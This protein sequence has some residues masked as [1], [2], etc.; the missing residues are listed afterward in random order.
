M[1]SLLFACDFSGKPL[2]VIGHVEESFGG[3]AADEPNAA[4]IARDALSA[5]GTA[6]DAAVALYFGLAATYPVAAGLGGGG[7]CL[8]HSATK[9]RVE[10]IDFSH[11]R[12]IGSGDGSSLAIP[13]NVRGMAALHARYGVLQWRQLSLP[14]ERA[15]RFGGRVSRAMAR[16]L[17]P[18]AG[19][20]AA[21]PDARAIFLHKDGTPLA[22]GDG[23]E[24]A[25]LATTIGQVRANGAGVLY[26]GSLAR[27]FATGAR[28]IGKTMPVEALRGWT[29]VWREPVSVNFGDHTVSLI[30]GSK[31]AAL[32][33]RLFAGKLY[34]DAEKPA[35]AA[36]VAVADILVN[37]DF[38]NRSSAAMP[39]DSGTTGFVVMDRAGGAVACG[40]AMNGAF[41]TGRI[42]PGTGVFATTSPVNATQ[43]G[44]SLAIISNVHRGDGYLAIAASGGS[45]SAAAMARVA[46]AALYDQ[47]PL[48]QALAAK[49]AI[50]DGPA[51]NVRAEPG[52]N[53][54]SLDALQ[55]GGSK[56]VT[57]DRL[58][59][60]NA[61]YCPKGILRNPGLCR[62]RTD[63]RGF[64]HA[65]SAG[66]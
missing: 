24:Q 18:A 58:G 39:R 49:R 8:V 34:A 30:P 42:I 57:D 47:I 26:G 4:I 19:R 36:A 16:S 23:I 6:A 52:T 38:A 15:A 61:I 1:L 25:A 35:K 32:W 31:S 22:E 53:R 10:L 5:G 14:G 50:A 41:G 62:Y 9:K 11:Q 56:I 46:G 12:S 43:I 20:L 7:M 65:V 3:A 21:D 45:A 17:R 33:R 2:G 48:G 40:F 37:A 51:R 44:F 60:V 55:R 64:G 54:A 13:A 29:P 28:A 66:N 59:R 63:P 27:R